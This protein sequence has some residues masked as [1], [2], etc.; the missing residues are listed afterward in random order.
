MDKF[1]SF[2]SNRRHIQI[3]HTGTISV[4]PDG[5]LENQTNR[6]NMVKTTTNSD[7]LGHFNSSEY[8]GFRMT[9]WDFPDVFVI[10]MKIGYGYICYFKWPKM[11]NRIYMNVQQCIRRSS[12]LLQ[13]FHTDVIRFFLT[14]LQNKF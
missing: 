4:F 3:L 9:I 1:H 8:F 6:F 14:L 12:E 5:M 7:Y 2:F 10:Y 13:G 11:T